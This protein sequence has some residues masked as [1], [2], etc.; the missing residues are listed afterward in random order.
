MS[1]KFFFV[2][3]YWNIHK[4]ARSCWKICAK[5][6]MA[7][8]FRCK[9]HFFQPL[10]LAKRVIPISH[11]QQMNNTQNTVISPNFLVLKFCG[12]AQFLHIFGQSSEPTWKLCLSTK[13]P[14]NKISWSYGIFRSEKH[15][16]FLHPV[17]E[18]TNTILQPELDT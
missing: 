16:H 7:M 6:K 17:D 9:Y 8:K 5:A 12:K 10:W 2:C 15:D 18:S 4:P 13:I 14:L 1:K 3:R 11:T